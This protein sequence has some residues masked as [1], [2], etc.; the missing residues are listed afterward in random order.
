MTSSPALV[1]VAAAA[2][3]IAAAAGL[4][5]GAEPFATWFYVFAWLP[6]L[7]LADAVHAWRAGRW[8][9]LGRPAF[10][11]TLFAWSAPF[12]LLFEIVNLRLANWFYVFVP[13]ARA[14]RWGGTLLSFATVLPAILTSERLL[15]AFGVAR[16]L[17]SRPFVVTEGL[18]IALQCAGVASMVLAL[19]APRFFFPLVWGALWLLA[20]PFVHRRDPER[21]LLGD[22]ER[23]RPGRIARLL[24]GGLAI[25]LVWEMF[26][27]RARGKWIY[28]V[29]GFEDGKLF[30][31][32][33][34][35]FLGF[36]F[37]ALEGFAVWQALVLSGLAVP[38]DAPSRPAPWTARVVAAGLVVAFSAL[39]LLAMDRGTVASTTPRLA[40]L[41]GAPQ[42]V[43]HSDWNVFSLARAR[44]E[45]VAPA[46]GIS[47]TDAERW[48]EAARLATL[49]GLGTENVARLH[50][51]GVTTVA[52]L[53]ASDPEELAARLAA[54]GAPIPPA[55]L[56]VW[57]R[58]A[59]EATR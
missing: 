19:L 49:R 43:A 1:A 56:R 48:V 53:A 36:P 44:P 12:W 2:M 14:P 58:T 17:R 22:L 35:G 4:A 27:I 8:F 30:E 33:L 42:V 28:T 10:A 59:R 55:R 15:D 41:P 18:R 57:V 26:N 13:A 29:P 6:T 40:E 31:M 9:L 25:G 20:D 50:A 52:E 34:L 7:I 37:F 11:A 5:Y 45:D 38:R 32:P 23:G 46:S 39:A 16:G 21:S 24:L 54:A 3:L 51:A 47:I